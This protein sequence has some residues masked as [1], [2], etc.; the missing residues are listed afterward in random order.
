MNEA[1]PSW[2]GVELQSIF[3]IGAVGYLERRRSELLPQLEALPEQPPVRAIEIGAHRGAF[4]VGMA[5]SHPEGLVLGLEKRPKYVR[6]AQERLE[7]LAVERAHMVL[8]DAKLAVVLGI[9]LDS[10]DAVYV[11]FPDPWWKEKHAE[12]RVLDPIFLRVLARRLR[13]GGRLY[14]KSDVFPYLHWVRECARLSEAFR[15]LPPERW[16]D[17]RTWTLTTRERKCMRSAIPFGRTYFERRADF[18]S[19]VPDVPE[20]TSAW[21]I[22]DLPD[23]EG[24]IRGAPPLDREERRARAK[25]HAEDAG[26][27]AGVTDNA[28]RS[29]TG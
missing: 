20:T 18:A 3:P 15:P 6:L 4:L 27:S 28:E 29:P 17:E 1:L 22:P 2:F 19:E 10:L 11:T 21:P 12:R 23:A 9:P 14:V 24:V 8:A 16:P 7:K 5:A 26:S 13:K 25:R